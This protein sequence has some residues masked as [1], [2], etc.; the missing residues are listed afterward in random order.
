MDDVNLRV[1]HRVWRN[2]CVIFMTKCRDAEIIILASISASIRSCNWIWDVSLSGNV[3]ILRGKA[4][5]TRVGRYS[6][7][8]RKRG[9]ERTGREVAGRRTGTND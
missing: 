9:R 2:E 5:S 6:L 8:N 1:F 7:E 3:I 4:V